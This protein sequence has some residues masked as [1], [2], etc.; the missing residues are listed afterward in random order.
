L[1]VKNIVCNK[2]CSLIELK[3]KMLM[4]LDLQKVPEVQLASI[5]NMHDENI[6][7][8]YKIPHMHVNSW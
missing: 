3:T 5:K 6:C 8:N 2:K 1:K 4:P 7:Y